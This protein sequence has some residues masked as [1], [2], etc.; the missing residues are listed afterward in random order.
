MHGVQSPSSSVCELVDLCAAR[1][2]SCDAQSAGVRLAVRRLRA[3]RIGA[4]N[5][6]LAAGPIVTGRCNAAPAPPSSRTAP[7]GKATETDAYHIRSQQRWTPSPT[8]PRGIV[9]ARFHPSSRTALLG[10]ACAGRR[11]EEVERKEERG[12]GKEERGRRKREG[13]RRK[14]EKEVEYTCI[15][16]YIRDDQ[17]DVALGRR[18]T[19]VADASRAAAALL[20]L[21]LPLNCGYGDF[22]LF[23]FQQGVAPLPDSGKNKSLEL[24]TILLW[25]VPS[26]TGC[27]SRRQRKHELMND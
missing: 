24:L 26:V 18:S 7:L 12:R 14:E 6:P 16:Y 22:V 15:I 5:S 1:H 13:G 10:R 23:A 25:V 2:R 9:Q 17:L 8:A 19:H 4:V 21:M 27:S 3:T 11:K 20:P